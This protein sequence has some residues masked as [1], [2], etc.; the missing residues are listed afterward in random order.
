MIPYEENRHFTRLQANCPMSFKLADQSEW[1]QGICFNISGSGILFQA[2]RAIDAGKAVEIHIV[3]ENK[4]TPPFTAFI[5]IIR[6]S[7]TDSGGFHLAGVIKGIKS[8]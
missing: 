8:E 1:F 5:E 3:P 7:P 2:E 6:C 4:L